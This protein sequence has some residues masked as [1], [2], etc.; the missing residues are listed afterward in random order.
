MNMNK[1]HVYNWQSAKNKKNDYKSMHSAVLFMWIHSSNG[2]RTESLD[3]VDTMDT[4]LHKSIQTGFIKGCSERQTKLFHCGKTMLN[5]DCRWWFS[6]PGFFLIN[7]IILLETILGCT[8]K[9][10]R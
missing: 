7:N 6:S 9:T 8:P 1:T 3:T 10:W 4:N 5:I 2:Y